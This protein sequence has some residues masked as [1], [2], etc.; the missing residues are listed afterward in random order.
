[1]G[2]G[3]YLVNSLHYV[4]SWGIRLKYQL[5]KVG[6]RHKGQAAVEYLMLVAVMAVIGFSILMRFKKWMLADCNVNRNSIMCLFHK[7]YGESN[8]LYFT[9]RK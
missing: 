6:E 8:F 5:V 9:L 7:I 1:M 2:I 3:V 4:A